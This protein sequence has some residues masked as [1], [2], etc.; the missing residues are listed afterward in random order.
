[1]L[2]NFADSTTEQQNCLYATNQDDIIYL[3]I[4]FF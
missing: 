2:L 1:M 4:Y 3:F